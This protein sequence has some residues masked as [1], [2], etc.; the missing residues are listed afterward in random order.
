MKNVQ[1][2]NTLS[3]LQFEI[4]NCLD[5]NGGQSDHL[6]LKAEQFDKISIMT[7]LSCCCSFLVSF[8][9]LYGSKARWTL[10][11]FSVS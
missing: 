6:K 5:A 1:Y 3:L 9:F 4:I 11:A 10:A 2:V 7:V 8:F